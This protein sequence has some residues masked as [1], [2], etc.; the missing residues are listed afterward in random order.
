MFVAHGVGYGKP[1]ARPDAAS[2]VEINACVSSAVVS[3]VM[4][5]ISAASATH[6]AT[7]ETGPGSN[8]VTHGRPHLTA[9]SDLSPVA[10]RL[11]RQQAE[12]AASIGGRLRRREPRSASSAA[13]LE[14]DVERGLVGDADGAEAGVLGTPRQGGPGRPVLRAR[15]RRPPSASAGRR[16]RPRPSIQLPDR[17]EVVRDR[18]SGERLD[19]HQR[20]VLGERL[21][22]APGRAQRIAQVVERVEEADQVVARSRVRAARGPLELDPLGD[23][24]RLGVRAGGRRPTPRAC[25]SRRSASARTPMPSGS[26][27]ARGR[28]RRPR[29]ARPARSFSTT[30]SSAGSHSGTSTA[31]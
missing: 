15:A 3:S 2:V 7:V 30:P 12:P 5:S 17:P 1:A 4:E 31:P 13:H 6:N 16:P 18:V 28:S 8:R 22:R 26:S 19:D 10:Q 9:S 27:S 29:R 21:V 25:R 11:L 23:T 24:R 20:P 14:D